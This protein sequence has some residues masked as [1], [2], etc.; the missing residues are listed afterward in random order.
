MVLPQRQAT[1][2]SPLP[3]GAEPPS[4][5]GALPWVLSAEA[6]EA[7]RPDRRAWGAAWLLLLEAGEAVLLPEFCEL[8]LGSDTPAG[9][10]AL[11]LDLVGPQQ[12]FRWRQGEITARP[13]ADLRPLRR[14]RRRKQLEDERERSWQSLLRNRQPIDLQALPIEQ[15]G[16]IA[17]LQQL[18]AG[19]IEL[20][21]L[22][23]G[24]RQSLSALHLGHDRGD[25]RHLL[26]ELG[27]WD[28]H[29]LISLEGTTWSTGFS[30]ELEAEA[31]RLLAVVDQPQPG[32]DTRVD[33]CALHTV[34]IDDDDTRDIDDALS[35]ERLDDGR[36]RNVSTPTLTMLA[37][38]SN[39]R[40]LFV[41]LCI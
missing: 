40:R 23:A 14:E 32:D 21:Q 34:T 8:V 11:W 35:L 27:Q 1:L 9:R 24:L 6:L 25:L 41:C 16:R 15:Q 38:R 5:L 37:M 39:L 18:A 33:L 26:V 36:I 12:W 3:A 30:A 22:D 28:Q 29:R 31:E 2:L 4:R 7:S 13:L 20:D 10:A 17:Q 19:R